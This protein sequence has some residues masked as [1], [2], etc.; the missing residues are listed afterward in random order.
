MGGNIEAT[1]LEERSEMR[2]ASGSTVIAATEMDWEQREPINWTGTFASQQIPN[3]NRVVESR[4]ILDDL[5]Y[6]SW[7]TFRF[8]I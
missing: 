8:A 7:P 2:S 3:D 1:G 6:G 5:R 4:K